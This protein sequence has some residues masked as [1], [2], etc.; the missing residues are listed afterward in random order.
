MELV[1]VSLLL[2][3]L[4]NGVWAAEPLS[5]AGA[6]QAQVGLE[7]LTAFMGSFGGE[8]INKYLV[9]CKT[10]SQTFKAEC[11]DKNVMEATCKTYACSDP[12][13]TNQ[14]ACEANSRMWNQ[15]GEAPNSVCCSW[16][17]LECE[18]CCD[19]CL[20]TTDPNYASMCVR[21]TM[22]GA[23]VCGTIGGTCN[24]CLGSPG[25]DSEHSCTSR[26]TCSNATTDSEA[27]CSTI[28]GT[29]TKAQWLEN[30]T[31]AG[32]EACEAQNYCGYCTGCQTCEED[33]CGTAGSCNIT[34]HYDRGSCESQGGNW[35]LASWTSFPALSESECEA[36]DYKMIK[37]QRYE[38]GDTLPAAPMTRMSCSTGPTYSM[39]SDACI[40]P[41]QLLQDVAAGKT[42]EEARNA[43]TTYY[44]GVASVLLLSPIVTNHANA[45]DRAKFTV[46]SEP[47]LVAVIDAKN[48][49][50]INF[51]GSEKTYAVLVNPTN[52]ADADAITFSGGSAVI[53][54]GT[55]SGAIN[56]DTTGKL[57]VFGVENSGPI[58]C[59]KSQD[60]L[61][62]NVTNKAGATI[63]VENVTATLINII[64]EGSVLVKGGGKYKAYGIVNLGSITIEAGDIELELLC[65]ASGSSG[66]VTLMEGVTGKVTYA[67]G[68]KGNMTV[69]SSG[70]IQEEVAAATT[71]APNATTAATTAAPTATTAATTAAPTATAA[72][73]TAATTAAPT[74]TTAATTAAPTVVVGSLTLTVSDCATFVA[75]SG[76]DSAIKAAL[77]EAT[78]ADVGTISVQL[79]CPSRRLA[80]AVLSRR[81]GTSV[82]A[83]YEISIP[84]GSSTVTATSVVNAVKSSSTTAMTGLVT[85]ALT[86]AN[87]P[88][89]GVSVATLPAPAEKV[90]VLLPG[91]SEATG[92]AMMPAALALLAMIAAV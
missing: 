18:G 77:S 92:L 80:S 89:A 90:P 70:V 2:L 65:P 62:A 39:G 32:A 56:V 81:L 21:E 69:P 47:C 31:A 60:I 59:K 29:W 86:A 10:K 36:L 48:K 14:S 51:Q 26:G 76:A 79:T 85:K 22:E 55:S 1:T 45:S 71:A 12:Q 15:N 7:N 74:A 34:T 53:L 63:T 3:Q 88:T 61:I 16:G 11:T 78:S 41:A 54:G 73:T 9:D 5:K 13:Y 30:T 75:Q 43:N 25:R 35:T 64:N 91:V 38:D 19:P 57:A 8:Y 83:A 44:T 33:S 68:C 49:G 27:E 6:L 82:A 40:D 24:Y 20:N 66:T 72:A 4:G 37:V 58:T 42:A 28:G 23:S 67:Q 50:E 84:A 46:T 87:L 17:G 52:Y